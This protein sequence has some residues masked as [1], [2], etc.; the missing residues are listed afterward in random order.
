MPST[1]HHLP[2]SPLGSSRPILSL[3]TGLES[4]SKQQPTAPFKHWSATP[5][6][7]DY[8]ESPTV[9]TPAVGSSQS[10]SDG[11]DARTLKTENN[12]ATAEIFNKLEDIKRLQTDI[13]VDHARLEKVGS[14]SDWADWRAPKEDDGESATGL[15]APGRSKEE[16]EKSSKSYESMAE[17]FQQRQEGIEGIMDKVRRSSASGLSC[18]P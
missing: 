18:R 4:G 13:A 5:A 11:H 10:H 9:A 16:K 17:E 1:Q 8:V 14:G 15:G 3:E 7:Y 12:S 2:P 6:S